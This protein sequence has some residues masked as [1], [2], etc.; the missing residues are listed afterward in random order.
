MVVVFPRGSESGATVST[1]AYAL[2]P[3]SLKVTDKFPAADAWA[4][5]RRARRR[6]IEGG[7]RRLFLYSG[8][9]FLN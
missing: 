1:L 2:T 3:Q 9:H 8:L 6:R 5:A 7:I 4:T